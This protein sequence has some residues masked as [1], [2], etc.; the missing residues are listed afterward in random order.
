MGRGLGF[1]PLFSTLAG[2]NGFVRFRSGNYALT[3]EGK[4][5]HLETARIV[6]KADFRGFLISVLCRKTA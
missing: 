4:A 3:L 1:R 6:Q 2:M 5:A